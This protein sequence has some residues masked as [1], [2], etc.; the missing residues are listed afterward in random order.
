MLAIYPRESSVQPDPMLILGKLWQ[1]TIF[2]LLVIILE[3]SQLNKRVL[4]SMGTH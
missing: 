1:S 3:Q 4:I 2:L